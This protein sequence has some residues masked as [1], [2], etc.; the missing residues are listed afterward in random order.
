RSVRVA[1]QGYGQFV[2]Q[3][4]G[5]GTGHQLVQHGQR[6][7]DGTAAGPDHQ[8]EDTRGHRHVLLPA[9]QFQILHQRFRRDQP[10]RVVVGARADGADDLVRLRGGEDELDVL[11]R[12]FDDLQQRV[13]AGGRDHVGLVDDEDLV[14]VAH[15][16][17]GGPFTQVAGVVH[18]AVRGGVDLNDV[19]AAGAA[20]AQFNAG[21]ALAARS[22]GGAFGAVQAAGQNAGGGGLAAAARTGEQ[23]GV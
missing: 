15:R 21:I 9:E 4:G 18:T 1:E 5:P 11:R 13:E 16:G 14:A 8:R 12:L 6:V 17:E 22:G 7:A 2:V 3:S 20:A 23:V 19:Q 10:E